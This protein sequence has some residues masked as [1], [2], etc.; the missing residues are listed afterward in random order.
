MRQSNKLTV[1][2]LPLVLAACQPKTETIPDATLSVNVL[3]I[4]EQP[5]Y[6]QERFIGKTAAIHK[7]DIVP[8]V[9]GYL[10]SR[11]FTE[12]ERV[13]KGDLLFE[14]DPALFEIEILRL[15]AALKETTA[16]F[17]IIDQKHQK[18]I[19]LVKKQA[20]SSLELDQL[21]AER[22]SSLAQIDADKAALSRANLELS[23]TKIKAPFDGIIGASQFSSGALVGPDH[24]ALT[25]IV[26]FDSVYVNIQLDEKQHVNNLQEQLINEGAFSTPNFTLQ[27]ANGAQYDH[28]G[29]S[30]FIDNHMDS[31]NGT[32]RFRVKFPNPDNLLIPGQFVTVT[33]IDSQ[34]TSA[35]LIP[36]SAIQE[37]QQGRYVLVVN[38]HNIVDAKY[39]Q[40]SERVRDN[41]L[42]ESGISAGERVIVEGL[43]SLTLG[44]EVDVNKRG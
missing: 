24:Q 3:T 29:E 16:D 9:S 31:L 27:L 11:H 4:T 6:H 10:K 21:T 36:Q 8:R 32:I 39:I 42:I 1:C 22:T 28:Q 33:S 18:A 5:Y 20:L 43:Q 34:P 40:V 14:I 17:N 35:I 13:N 26:S 7:V 2:L 44:M 25:Q 37:D 15:E 30:N 23:Y 41:W 12:G 38:D 19:A